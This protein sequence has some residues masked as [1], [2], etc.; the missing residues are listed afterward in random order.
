MG[1]EIASKQGIV[2]LITGGFGFLGTSLVNEILE[3]S[4]PVMLKEL[5]V[6][7]GNPMVDVNEGTPYPKP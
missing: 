7:D 2:A 3:K 4:S 1:T 5:R 6:F